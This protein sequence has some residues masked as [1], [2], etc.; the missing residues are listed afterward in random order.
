MYLSSSSICISDILIGVLVLALE[1]W[2]IC[3]GCEMLKVTTWS[4]DDV[5]ICAILDIFKLAIERNRSLRNYSTPTNEQV[6]MICAT[7]SILQ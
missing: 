2:W 1:L 5:S 6:R 3:L 4:S 7:I